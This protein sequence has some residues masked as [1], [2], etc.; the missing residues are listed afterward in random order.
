LVNVNEMRASRNT[1]IGLVIA[2][3]VLGIISNEAFGLPGSERP[4]THALF[5]GDIIIIVL[6]AI[7]VGVVIALRVHLIPVLSYY[8]GQIFQV[9]QKN[10][11]NLAPYISDLSHQ[12]ANVITVGIIWPVVIKALNRPAL[13]SLSW[14]VTVL[15]FVFL[16]ILLYYLWKAYQVLQPTLKVASGVKLARTV[17]VAEG[18]SETDEIICPECG[19]A[20]P[21]QTKFCSSCGT[22]ITLVTAEAITSLNCPKCGTENAPEAKFCTKCGTPLI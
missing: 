22:E 11:K 3:V 4:V 17:V 14:I 8:L 16:A 19:T 7:S 21:P 12:I 20:N 9:L 1:L 10:R 6:A 15:I 18:S 5:V 2:L 13:G